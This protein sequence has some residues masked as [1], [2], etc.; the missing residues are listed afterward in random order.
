MVTNGLYPDAA[1]IS[2]YSSTSANARCCISTTTMAP[3]T[4]RL[5]WTAMGRWIPA[6][7]AI[8]N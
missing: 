6:S 8:A 4:M 1:R 2:D 5:T 7:A 3:G